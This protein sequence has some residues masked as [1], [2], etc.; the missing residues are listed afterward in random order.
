MNPSEDRDQIVSAAG[1]LNWYALFTRYQH[2]KP[3]ALALSNKNYEVYLPLCN[4][5]RQWQDR[6]K[7]LW[8]PLF[9]SYV[10]VRGGM[11]RPLQ[12]L[13]TPGVIHIVRFGGQPAIVSETHL[14]AVRKILGSHAAVEPHPYLACGDRV[15]V[16]S[17][18]LAGLEGILIRKKNLVQLIIS[19][20]ML[21]RSA[22]V[23]VGMSN[24]ERV[25]AMHARVVTSRMTAV[26]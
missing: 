3:V 1:A 26:A 2:E 23:E 20:Q 16:K 21:G 24:I 11:D 25:G 8:F 22:A 13:S 7:Q 6:S 10:F 15:R 19:M 14:D 17:G 4:S 5:T 18:A 9:P 12:I